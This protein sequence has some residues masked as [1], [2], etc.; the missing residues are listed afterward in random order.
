MTTRQKVIKKV[1]ETLSDRF[2]VFDNTTT[3]KK[4]VSGQFPDVLIYKKEPQD[5]DEILFLMKIENGG[6][7]VDSVSQWKELSKTPSVFYIITPRDK[8]DDAKKLV[9]ATG[10]RARLGWYE[11][12]NEEVTN[13]RFE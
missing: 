13:L 2:R 7:L 10:I 4:I 11:I 5:D 12:S 6:E 9:D 3:D 8:L 1:I